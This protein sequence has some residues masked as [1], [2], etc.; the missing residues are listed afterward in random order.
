M[1]MADMEKNSKDN[2]EVLFKNFCSTQNPRW[3]RR[4]YF[5][6]FI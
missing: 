5:N 2:C 4:K 3:P 6:V 1:N